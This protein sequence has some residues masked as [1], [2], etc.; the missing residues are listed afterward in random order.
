MP[1]L[2][3]TVVDVGEAKPQHSPLFTLH[4]PL[5]QQVSLYFLPGFGYNGG[6]RRD[7]MA[8]FDDPKKE[9]RRLEQQLRE[10]EEALRQE[11]A[12]DQLLEEYLEE[13]EIEDCF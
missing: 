5:S 9:L 13:A 6:Q 10:E 3:M 7:T 11:E 12:L 1:L 2:A 4:T 8:L